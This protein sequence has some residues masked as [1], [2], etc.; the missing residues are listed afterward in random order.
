MKAI[1]L[2]LVITAAAIRTAGADDRVLAETYFRAGEQAYR[3]QSFAAAATDFEEAYRALPLPEIAS[4]AAQAYRRLFRI[5]GVADHVTR[6][7]ELY[8]AYLAKV[9]TGGRVADAADAL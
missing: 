6:A 4:S 7:I 9:Q 8:H 1:V 3:A 5:D 2:A